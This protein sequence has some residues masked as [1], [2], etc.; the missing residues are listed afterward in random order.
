MTLRHMKIFVAVYQNNSITKAA[1]QLHIVQPSVSLAIKELE[2][3]YGIC[4][5]DRIGRRIYPTA[6]GANFYDYALHIV[7]LFDEMEQGIR[8]WDVLGSVRV[9]ASVTIGNL[10]LPQIVRE[11]GRLYPD[12]R[13]SVTISNAETI[14]Q[15]VM[16]NLVDFALTEGETSIP[17]LWQESILKDRFCV[18]AHPSHPLSGMEKAELEDLLPYPLL[19]REA[20]S[21]SRAMVDSLFLSRNHSVTPAWESTS[22]QALVRG[23]MN[24][25]GIAIIPYYL[26]HQEITQG[27][28]VEIPVKLELYRYFSIICHRNKYLS[29]SARAFLDLCRN[30]E[31]YLG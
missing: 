30:Y 15:S 7:S 28:V 4:L 31:L 24:N 3:Y 17:Q 18:I 29:R 9:G 26:A 22:T 8:D 2:N 27:L 20:G 12:I 6:S 25:L 11:F 1:E 14:E 23:V 19:L 21:A 10:L 16:D 5:F 13:I